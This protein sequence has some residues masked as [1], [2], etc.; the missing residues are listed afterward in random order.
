M[1]AS[2]FKHFFY[3]SY[4]MSWDETRLKFKEEIKNEKKM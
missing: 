4:F 1:N 2:Q 3:A